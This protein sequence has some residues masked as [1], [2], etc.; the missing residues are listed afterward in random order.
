MEKENITEVKRKTG[1][2]RLTEIAGR[3]KWWLFGSIFFAIMSTLLQFVPVVVVYLILVELATHATNI[4]LLNQEYLFNLAFISLVSVAGFGILLYI[5]SML[6]HIAAFNI[7]YEIRV[8][9][10]DK[11]T[12]L[13]MGFFTEKT[14][15]EIKKVMSEDVE[16]IEN[17]VAHHIP[18]ITSGIV[19]PIILILYLIVADWRLGLVTVVPFFAAIIVQAR[20]NSDI[21][22][23]RDYHD[24]LQNINTAVVEY[25]RGMPVIKVFGATAESFQSLREATYSLRDF[26]TRVTEEYSSVYPRFL[27]IIS[28]SLL[29]IIPAAVFLLTQSPYNQ[30]VPTVLLFMI[31]GGG[32][33]FPLYKLMLVSGLIRQIGVGT[34]RIDSIL[35]WEEMIEI[36]TDQH[37][38]DA[39]VTFDE[40]SFSYKED[41]TLSGISFQAEPGT[42]TALVGP[43]G[44]GKT[45]IGLLTARFW[46]VL[47]GAIR[48]GS[49]DIR[50]MKVDELM[51]YVSFVFQ[52]SFLFFDTIEENIRIG[53]HS[54]SRE[55]VIAAAKAAQCHDFIEALPKGYDTLIGEGGT[56]LSGGETQRIAIARLILKDTPIVVL[57]EATAFADPENESKILRAFSKLTMDK[58]VIVIAHRLSTVVN[59]DQI[60]VIDKGQIVQRGRHSELASIDGLYQKMWDSFNRSRDWRIQ[61][62]GGIIS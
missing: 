52:D 22:L 54:A 4:M 53:N 38:T 24:S 15:G 26:S 6:S 12:Q 46:D 1:I 16:K 56:Y 59:A 10:S 17:Y 62:E 32:M 55:D 27:T 25:V 58:T 50:D 61:K 39:S 11:L 40:V 29:F 36:S 44:A 3:K 35:D 30:Y 19:F 57:D 41:I 5:S 60:L 8:R 33:F 23:Y 42:V 20:M 34:E 2:R 47:S 28:S 45:T 51:E 7:L 14:S 43:S 9:I 31:I 48:I 21:E 18:D 13:S 37:P 49:V